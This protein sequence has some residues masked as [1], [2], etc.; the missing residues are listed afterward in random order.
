MG[1]ASLAGVSN[2]YDFAEWALI[3]YKHTTLFYSML[4][5]GHLYSAGEFLL[6]Y[7]HSVH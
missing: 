5:D 2:V 1:Q 4:Y 7:M 3:R 6:G